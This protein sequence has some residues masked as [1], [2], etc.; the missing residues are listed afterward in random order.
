MADEKRDSYTKLFNPILEALCRQATNL[1]A[2]DYAIILYVIRCTY[3]WH[4]TRFAMSSAFISKGTGIPERSVKRSIKK[5]LQLNYLKEFG[6]EGRIKLVGLNKRYS[7]WNREGV[8]DDTDTGDT[9]IVSSE[10]SNSDTDDTI[11]SVT[12]DT[13]KRKIQK[14]DSKEKEKKCSQNP[15]FLNPET[16]M[17]E[18]VE[19][20]DG[21]D[22]GED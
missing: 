17:W 3:G 15:Y 21:E 6:K 8:M 10:V 5:L 13:Q 14:K 9:L 18:E 7:Q 1:S 12:D 20:E 19:D 11:N 22:G 2:N 16:G 4:K